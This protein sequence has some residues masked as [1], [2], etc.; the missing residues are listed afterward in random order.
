M[1]RVLIVGSGGREHALA[2]KLSHSSRV[3]Q[4][5]LAPGNAGMN[6]NWEFWPIT[7]S[8]GVSAFEGL[9]KR[10]VQ[11]SVD[12]VIVGPDNA[13]AEGIVN[14]FD[15]FKLPI[16]G[17][18]SQAARLESSKAF[19]K[20]VMDAAGVPTAKY[21]VVKS[22]EDAHKILHS[23][24]WSASSGW[25]IKA[26][27][28]ALGKG[29]RVCGTQKEALE[30][31]PELFQFSSTLIIEERLA[32][33]EVSWMAFC[34]GDRC[35]LLETARDYKRLLDQNQGPNTGGM[36][37]YSP[38]RG[39]S[40]EFEK[41]IKDTV[42]LPV[43]SEMKK[44]DSEFKGLLYAGLM[45][46]FKSEKFWV[47]EFNARFGDPEAQ[48][49][50]PRIQGDLLDWVEAVARGDLSGLPASVPFQKNSA[51]FVVAASPG[52]PTQPQMGSPVLFQGTS[53]ESFLGFFSGVKK[54][55]ISSVSENLG[56]NLNRLVTSGGRVLGALGLA[57]TQ[58]EARVSAYQ[59]LEKVR[60]SGMQF[61][62]DIGKVETV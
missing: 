59:E 16:F 40:A 30:A 44:R 58:E 60:F 54:E 49:L 10:A 47:L 15:R 20:E 39:I 5:I 48:V 46:D 4:I 2:W 51:V 8:D 21:W 13:L 1:K 53:Q 50:L 45:V 31:L 7:L 52:Y 32:G 25:V 56:E 41:T 29:V 6:S 62:T 34:D 35:A 19:A 33:E 3:S 12:L 61:R 14:V 43:L 11:E 57:P 24:P 9:A 18:T 27:G 23:V 22:E 42:F 17:P 36:G 37:A 38:V 26:D 55:A 28:L